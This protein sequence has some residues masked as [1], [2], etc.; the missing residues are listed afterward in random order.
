LRSQN[1]RCSENTLPISAAIT[2]AA[3]KMKYEKPMSSVR[4]PAKKSSYLINDSIKNGRASIDMLNQ[5]FIEEE[6][7]AIEG[8]EPAAIT[9]EE[10][11]GSE[12]LSK[13]YLVQVK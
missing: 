9:Q 12:K 10:K 2:S 3:E 6:E 11:G 13:K 5:L 7:P 4:K 1:D 8:P